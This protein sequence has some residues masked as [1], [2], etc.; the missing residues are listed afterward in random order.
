VGLSTGITAS[1]PPAAQLILV[2][3]MFI[4]RLGPVALGSALALTR[5]TRLYELPK[6]RPIIG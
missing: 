6:E 5:T 4:G 2:A 3:L 1:L